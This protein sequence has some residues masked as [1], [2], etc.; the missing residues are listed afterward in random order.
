M[1][2]RYPRFGYQRIAPQLALA[3]GIEV[4]KDTFAA[5]SPSAIGQ[6]PRAPRGSRSS[7]TP[8][9]ACG[10]STSFAASR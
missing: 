3:F 7:R 2:R 6:I 9:I 8:K 1:K 5:S 10:P 4:D